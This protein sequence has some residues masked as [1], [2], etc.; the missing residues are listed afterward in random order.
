MEETKRRTEKM[1]RKTRVGKESLEG[2]K[3]KRER[4]EREKEEK[5]RKKRK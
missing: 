5:E 2:R 4:R 3:R 1:G